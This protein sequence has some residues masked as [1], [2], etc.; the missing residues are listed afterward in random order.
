MVIMVSLGDTVLQD[1]QVSASKKF[2]L[3]WQPIISVRPGTT[4]C[5]P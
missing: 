4:A 5:I 3:M 1:S 2:R